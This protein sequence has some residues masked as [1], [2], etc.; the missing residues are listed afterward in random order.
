MCSDDFYYADNVLYC[1]TIGL[2]K[3]RFGVAQVAVVLATSCE[4]V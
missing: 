3:Y 4:W 2:C 1:Y